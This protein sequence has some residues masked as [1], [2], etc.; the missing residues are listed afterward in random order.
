MNPIKCNRCSLNICWICTITE[1][2]PDPAGLVTSIL[3]CDPGKSDLGELCPSHQV[4]V[5]GACI[6]LSVF[7]VS[8]QRD[9]DLPPPGPTSRGPNPPHG[10]ITP[11]E[12]WV[13]VLPSGNWR[14]AQGCPGLGVRG[15]AQISAPEQ[16]TG[17]V[18]CAGKLQWPRPEIW[19]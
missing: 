6:L 10:A 7:C 1:S 19:G 14:Q 17:Q 18:V 5:S 2:K 12:G 9:L 15:Q 13:D 3:V 16:A 8:T 4:L 11:G